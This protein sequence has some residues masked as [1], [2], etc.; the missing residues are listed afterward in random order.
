MQVFRGGSY[1]EHVHI[2]LHKYWFF[3]TSTTDIMEE[4]FSAMP[5]K[6]WRSLVALALHT[7]NV[8]RTF[9]DAAMSLDG[10]TI[11]SAAIALLKR[12]KLYEMLE[13][14]VGSLGA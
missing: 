11:C 13:L 6:G 4:V 2:W 3:G 1:W 9:I 5:S 8:P 14:L 10:Q 12:G 7:H